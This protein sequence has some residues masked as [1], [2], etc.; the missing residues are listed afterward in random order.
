M[1]GQ[2]SRQIKAT[3]PPGSSTSSS[4]LS[5]V[6]T[7]CLPNLHACS[8]RGILRCRGM[9]IRRVSVSFGKPRIDEPARTCIDGAWGRERPGLPSGQSIR[10]TITC[11]TSSTLH[12]P[13]SRCNQPVKPA[14]KCRHRISGTLVECPWCSR[15]VGLLSAGRGTTKATSVTLEQRRGNSVEL[16]S[17]ATTLRTLILFDSLPKVSTL[18]SFLRTL[19]HSG[20]GDY[21]MSVVLQYTITVFTVKTTMV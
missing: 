18:W 15:K 10:T 9:E 14:L 19:T 6:C 4:K 20:V 5:P 13:S 21:D 7:T 3:R 8:V 1:E 16:C 2:V 11:N 12:V 17:D